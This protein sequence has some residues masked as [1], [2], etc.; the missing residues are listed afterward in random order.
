V[1]LRKALDYLHSHGWVHGHLS[2]E[3]V[4]AVGDSIRLSTEY[5]GQINAARPLQLVAAK[6]LAPEAATGNITPAADVWCLGATLF[7]ALAQHVFSPER[8][9]EAAAFPQPFD[10]IVAGCVEVN[11]QTRWKLEQVAAALNRPPAAVLRPEPAA[12]AMPAVEE[13]GP[14]LTHSPRREQRPAAASSK[15]W[16]YAAAAGLVVLLLLWAAR[17]RGHRYVPVQAKTVSQPLP[18]P[19]DTPAAPPKTAWETKTLAPPAA[20][21]SAVTKTGKPAADPHTINGSVWR[22]VVFTYNREPEA[23]KKAQ[24]VNQK[25]PNLDAQVFSP[26]GHGSAYLVTV[27][28]KMTR[29]QAEQLRRRVIAMGLPHDTYIQNYKQ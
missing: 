9:S 18:A 5:A 14:R 12:A 29:E 23:E 16:I 8:L 11:P 24:S 27:G 3:Q 17:P 4:L 20:S 26:G 10:R 22:V 1:N 2:P 21:R 13:Q 7:E 19:N 6:Y 28:G 25:H 15:F